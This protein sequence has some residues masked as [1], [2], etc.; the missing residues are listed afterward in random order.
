MDTKKTDIIVKTADALIKI[1]PR[2][3]V[4]DV[5]GLK[6]ELDAKINTEVAQAAHTEI[7]KK[8]ETV[9]KGIDAKIEVINTDLAEKVTGTK[10]TEEINAV[11]E[12]TKNTLNLKA[13]VE[14]VPT[15]VSQLNNDVNFTTVEATNVA[16]A[17]AV[18]EVNHLKAEVVE[19]L[20]TPEE[21]IPNI[22][23]LLAKEGGKEGDSYDEYMFINGKIE[24]I[25]NT[26]IDLTNYA[27]Y[28]DLAV[29]NTEVNAVKES[30]A[31]LNTDVA[32]NLE[33]QKTINADVT[34]KIEKTSGDIVR[35]DEDLKNI[36]LEVSGDI[37]KEVNKVK[38]D[39]KA[40]NEEVGKLKVKVEESEGKLLT[41]GTAIEQLELDAKVFVSA[42]EPEN[43]KAGDIW[44]KIVED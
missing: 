5:E 31:K 44:L 18:N 14:D 12:E 17:K 32:E 15:K 37:S 40:T 29:V 21:A 38:E 20:P 26:D 3:D 25:G 8:I 9:T 42:T 30:V 6:A 39:I 2:T 33:K 23:Y 43:I 34:A 36:K 11:K 13:N 1:I 10:L 19:A 22:I 28:D 16:I 41:Q 24:L 4:K 35:I 27:K 7:N